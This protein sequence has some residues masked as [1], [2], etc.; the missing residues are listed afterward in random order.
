MS[1][2]GDFLF[3]LSDQQN[4]TSDEQMALNNFP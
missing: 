2:I 4:A 3:L 1:I